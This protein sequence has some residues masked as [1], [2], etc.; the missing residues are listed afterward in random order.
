MIELE[1]KLKERTEEITTLERE[2]KML[3]IQVKSK[4]RLKHLPRS[5]SPAD[6]GMIPG[7]HLTRTCFQKYV[8]HQ[9]AK[10]LLFEK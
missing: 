7:I 5:G 2:L 6:S 9:L 8:G 10:N 4:S 3:Q 1:K